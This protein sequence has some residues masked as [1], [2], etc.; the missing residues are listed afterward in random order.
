MNC[1]KLGGLLACREHQNERNA[2]YRSQFQLVVV[3]NGGHPAEVVGF[4]SGK[5]W[6]GNQYRSLSSKYVMSA[7]REE[8]LRFKL[9]YP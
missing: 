6:I 8:Q 5:A 2:V 7:V 3:Q 9:L 4:R 1:C